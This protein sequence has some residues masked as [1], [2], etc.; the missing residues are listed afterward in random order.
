M[1]LLSA[2]MTPP[3]APPPNADP[4]AIAQWRATIEA[5]APVD[6][7]VLKQPQIQALIDAL[8]KSGLSV[9]VE[10]GIRP[11]VRVLG[12]KVDGVT[13]R[14]NGDPFGVFWFPTKIRANLGVTAFKQYIGSIMDPVSNMRFYLCDQLI[15]NYVGTNKK[16]FDVLAARCDPPF[17]QTG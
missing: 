15:V 10:E 1:A 8:T 4:T 7:N 16:V 12:V 14:V 9:R 13:F 2:C 6:Q 17:I 11:E 5:T 3:P